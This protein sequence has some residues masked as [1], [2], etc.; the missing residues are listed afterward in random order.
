MTQPLSLVSSHFCEEGGVLDQLTIEEKT[1]S[2]AILKN[3]NGEVIFRKDSVTH[4]KSWSST[5]VTTAAHKYFYDG[6]N[7]VYDLIAR[8][9]DT[10]TRWGIEEN[11]FTEKEGQVFHDELT[12]ILLT[13][14]ASFNS[15][16]WFN[17]GTPE[18]Q[19][20]SAC[21]IENV[22]DKM[23]SIIDLQATET[24]IF[25][26][27][28]GVGVN[29]SSL[30]S[31]YEPISGR[32]T[33]SSGPVAFMRGLDAW[34]GVMKSGGKTRRAAMIFLLNATHPDI[35]ELEDGSTGFVGLKGEEER[36][37]KALAESG[38]SAQL[39]GDMKRK[40]F[41]QNANN[42]VRVTDDF[43]SKACGEDPD[44]N[45]ST[46]DVV[47]GEPRHLLNAKDVLM[48]IAKAAHECGDP[49]LQFNDTINM[50]HTCP[51]SGQIEATNPCQPAS[52]LLLTPDGLRSLGDLRTGD[53]VWSGSDWTKIVNKV[54]RGIKPVYKYIT[55]SGS[56]LGTK[57]HHIVSNGKKVE[58][59][60]AD[61]IDV[62]CGPNPNVPKTYLWALLNGHRFSRLGGD[63]TP[64]LIQ[65]PQILCSFLRGIFSGRGKINEGNAQ[66]TLRLKDTSSL[67]AVQIALSSVGIRSQILDQKKGASLVINEDLEKFQHSVGFLLR[68]SDLNKVVEA[69]SHREPTSFE[70]QSRKI[71]TSESCG[72]QEVFDIAVDAPEHTY[73]TQ[74][75]L[76]SNCAEYV[77][78][79]HTSCNLASINLDKFWE[80][81]NPSFLID[82]YTH[83]IRVMATAMDIL[84]SRADYPTPEI[85]KETREYRTIGLG[86]TNLGT[87][88]LGHGIPYDSPTG[89]HFATA[90][91]SLLTATAYRQS[92]KIAERLSPFPAFEKNR[93]TMLEIIKRHGECVFVSETP[94]CNEIMGE[95][96]LCWHAVLAEGAQHG[97]RNAQVSVVAPTGT[98]SILMDCDSTG[99]EPMFQINPVKTMIDGGQLTYQMK[100]VQRALETLGYDNT[101][102]IMQEIQAGK[103]DKLHHEDLAVFDCALPAT[104]G[105]RCLTPDAH[106]KMMEA[107]QPF[108]SGAISKTV[109]VPAEATVEDVFQLYIS[110][111]RMEL[112]SVAIYRDGSKD[113][114]PLR[115]GQQ[116]GKTKSGRRRLPSE[117]S[118][119]THKFSVGGLKGYVVVGLFE[120]GTPGELF[121]TAS[122]QG[123]VIQGLMD[124]FATSFSLN[125]QYGV[126]LDALI[127]KFR[128]AAFEPSGFTGNPDIPTAR[129]LVAYIVRWLDH[130]FAQKDAEGNNQKIEEVPFKT[131]LE[132]GSMMKPSGGF[133]CYVCPNCASSEGV[134]G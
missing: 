42:S 123:S 88:L 67:E 73:W 75:L 107:V 48:A 14:R 113:D 72:D 103:M 61:T 130:K 128:N 79:P 47:S 38:W 112:K 35:L 63:I 24:K 105:G 3:S 86:F 4:P 120:D 65:P 45:Y 81:N 12:Y 122:E 36:K 106:L 121:V 43:M 27:G 1:V 23:E 87:T 101:E 49:G 25:R 85:A 20:I 84:I 22:E 18:S 114:Q 82:D 92:S 15:P 115:S 77:F 53:T 70:T 11:Y 26:T 34:G 76:V 94:V 37:A 133:N 104:P 44:P 83:T 2:D 132:C 6:E 66:V 62:C 31:S 109:N 134:C 28:A 129:S 21:Y 17:L 90:I 102:E 13:Q 39:H 50:W 116:L 89:R 58:V 52:A 55:D 126:P 7:S 100:A 110:A 51:N 117:R 54:S 46:H 97:F 40:L 9:V 95:A 78:L 60:K 71:I 57:E 56:F 41:F 8:V 91:A 127:R 64:A 16:V 124:A 131:C 68:Q 96:E 69:A 19:A 108:I 59:Q 80:P 33:T 93:D 10:I 98:I 99:I 32:G 74:G 30:R 29:L 118:S 119:I 125:L 111:W 5:A